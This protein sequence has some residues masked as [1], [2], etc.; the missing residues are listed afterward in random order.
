MAIN[1]TT[2]ERQIEQA[3][4][5]IVGTAWQNAASGASAQLAELI[6][7]GQQIEAD[8]KNMQQAEYDSLKLMEQRALDGVLQTFAGISRDIAEQAAAAAWNVLVDAVKAAYP[9]T[10]L[11]L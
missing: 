7:A 9:A 3:V 1:W 6:A 10:A 11:I 8:R 4:G 5:G 2:V